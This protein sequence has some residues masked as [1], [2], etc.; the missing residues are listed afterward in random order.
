M[1]ALVTGGAGFIG[2]HVVEY[3]LDKGYDVIVMDNFSTGSIDN[4]PEGIEP[5]IIHT[6]GSNERN[7]S[8]FM[9]E[10]SR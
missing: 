10:E 8:N 5:I 9:D 6:V 7:S 2:S 4:L 3:L 1:R